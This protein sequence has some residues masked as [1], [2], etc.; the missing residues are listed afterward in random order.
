VRFL[1]DAQLRPAL[2]AWL[3]SRG[4]DAV[5]VREVGLRDA[6]DL[7]IWTR[8]GEEDF[9][10]VTKD[11]DFALLAGTDVRGPRVLW[12]RCGNLVNRL[13]LARFDLTWPD[14]ER[15]LAGD[16]RVVELR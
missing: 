11:E 6:D 9:I 1:V 13:L 15:H 2:A 12:V 8:A 14:I 10:I 3:R 4:H 16:V 7:A 5:A